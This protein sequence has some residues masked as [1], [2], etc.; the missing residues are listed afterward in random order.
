MQKINK[1]KTY[2][3]KSGKFNFFVSAIKYLKKKKIEGDYAETGVW[4]GG[5]SILSYQMFSEKIKKKK[6]F[7]LYDTFEGMT[8]LVNSIKN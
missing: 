7:Y 3:G 8:K 1:I 4:K 5:L 6:R 2:Y